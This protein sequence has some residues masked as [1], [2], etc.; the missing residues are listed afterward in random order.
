MILVYF[1]NA[2]IGL[3]NPDLLPDK[4][5]LM[6]STNLKPICNGVKIRHQKDVQDINSLLLTFLSNTYIYNFDVLLIHERDSAYLVQKEILKTF[7]KDFYGAV[8]IPCRLQKT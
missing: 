5:Q 1:Q 8:I 7:R 3:L 2:K 6:S 4:W